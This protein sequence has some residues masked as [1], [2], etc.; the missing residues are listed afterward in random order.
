MAL[1]PDAEPPLPRPGLERGLSCDPPLRGD[2]ELR[3]KPRAQELRC[4]PGRPGSAEGP[5]HLPRSWI[6]PAAQGALRG[7]CR[8]RC[9]GC[10]LSKEDSLSKD[11]RHGDS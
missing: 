1:D 4:A 3:S 10:D 8:R 2:L 5:R 6:P 11:L 9:P 7:A